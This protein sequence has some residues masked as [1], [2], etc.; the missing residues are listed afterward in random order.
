MPQLTL[1]QAMVPPTGMM[2]VQ[3]PMPAAGDFITEDLNP[4]SGSQDSLSAFPT[5]F[6]ARFLRP[7]Q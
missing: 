1:A 3:H 4:L 6:S 7:V 5:S 2:D